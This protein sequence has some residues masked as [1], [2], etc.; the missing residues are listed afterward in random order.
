MRV[1]IAL[2]ACVFIALPA[3]ADVEGT[4]A[5][6]TK[7]IAKAKKQQK[8]ILYWESWKA[9]EAT[10]SDKEYCYEWMMLNTNEDFMKNE[11]LMIYVEGATK[12]KGGQSTITEE[13]IYP[14]WSERN[15]RHVLR[16]AQ[17]QRTVSVDSHNRYRGLDDK[18]HTLRPSQYKK[19]RYMATYDGKDC[20]AFYLPVNHTQ[21]E[22]E[23]TAWYKINEKFGGEPEDV[24]LLNWYGY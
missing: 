24:T 20:I 21:N 12:I 4:I 6:T 3:F 7:A 14:V 2:I 8:P 5:G 15:S 17:V 22:L 19:V 13:V 23:S 18:L 16:F 9:A 1:F 11:P 10:I